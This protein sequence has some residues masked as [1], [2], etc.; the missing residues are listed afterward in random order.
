MMP[1]TM[2]GP[3]RLT[4]LLAMSPAMKPRT[5]H[6]NCDMITSGVSVASSP[7]LSGAKGPGGRRRPAAAKYPKQR[8]H[9]NG[10]SLYGRAYSAGGA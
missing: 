2:L 8:S 5:I 10:R 6:W 4:I 1:I 9:N 7:D 3:A